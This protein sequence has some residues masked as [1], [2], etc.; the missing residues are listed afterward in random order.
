GEAAGLS[1][2]DGLVVHYVDQVDTAHQVL[3]RDW[4][5]SRLPI[6][7]VSSGQVFMAHMP[8]AVV[9]RLLAR[10]LERFTPSTLVAPVA[11][12]DR[13]RRIQLDGYVWGGGEFA[14]G[15]NSVAAPIA[16]AAGNVSAA[17]HVHGPAYRFPSEGARMDIAHEVLAA[18]ARISGR[19]RQGS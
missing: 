16:D 10:P 5:G 6:H 1:V 4:T 9:E 3:V 15:I 18:A 14:E 12:Q 8:P 13:L 19:L 7:A 2:L 11:V 17:V